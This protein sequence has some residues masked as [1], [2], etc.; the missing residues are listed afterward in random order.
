VSLLLIVERIWKQQCMHVVVGCG[1]CYFYMCRSEL[2][3]RIVWLD[4]LGVHMS[5][6]L[7]DIVIAYPYCRYLSSDIIGI[8]AALLFLLYYSV[9]SQQ[10]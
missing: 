10:T 3:F 7:V 6:L 2:G 4:F 1:G 9:Y 5:Y 8:S